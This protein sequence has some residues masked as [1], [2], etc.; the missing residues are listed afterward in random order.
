MQLQAVEELKSEKI[1]L[2]LLLHL[3]NAF[4][5]F[6]VLMNKYK[7]VWETCGGVV[8]SFTGSFDEMKVLTNMGLYIG[9]NGCSLRSEE[10]L[11]QVVPFIPESK[12]IFETDAPYC[13]VRPTHPGHKLLDPSSI[14]KTAKPEKFQLGYMV[15]GRNEPACISQVATIV[16]RARGAD[17]STLTQ[18]VHDNTLRLFT[19]LARR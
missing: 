18:K 11:T 15:K 4:D 1:E 8:H 13:D 17:V 10:S 6:V 2:P 19:K 14:P 5:D 9:L 3:R 7:H 12:I 16:A